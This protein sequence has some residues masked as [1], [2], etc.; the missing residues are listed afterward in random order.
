MVR[1][2]IRA[3]AVHHSSPGAVL[4]QLNDAI[5]R[6]HDDGRFCT[7]L[8]GRVTVEPGRARIVIAGGGHPPPLVRRASGAVETVPCA[9]PLLGIVPDVAH[10]D[11]AIELGP[12]DALVCFTDGVTEGRRAGGLFGERR[13]AE[14]IAAAADGADAIADRVVGAVLDFQGGRT[15]D[16]LALLVLRVPP[17]A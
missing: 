8:H 17:R 4:G 14:E 9:G 6:H 2:T 1:Y 12:G 13:L 15:H 10:P 16:D 5:L 3:E 11:V 7:V